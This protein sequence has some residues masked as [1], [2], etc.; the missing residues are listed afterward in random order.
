M[1]LKRLEENTLIPLFYAGP[2]LKEGPLPTV[3]Y[4]AL[5]AE[6]SLM[7]D[8]FNQ[9]VSILVNR[10]IR[11][12]SCDLPFHGKDFDSREALAGWAHAF[13]QGKDIVSEFLVNLK[14]SL[15]RLISLGVV[16]NN[17]IGCMGVSRGGFLISHLAAR[18]E[19]IT[20]L[21]HFAPLTQI[22]EGKDFS[23]LELSPLLQ[24]LNL[25]NF[26][27]LLHAKTQRIYIGNRDTRVGTSSCFNWIS[28]LV[29]TA[30]ENG[31]RSPHIEL[32]IKPS[33]GHMGHGTSKESFEQGALWLAEQMTK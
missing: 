25:T 32:F 16:A 24:N 6:E 5:S 8:P 22:T 13:A 17:T 27:Y 20:T 2:Y 29:E 31:I 15:S 7:T 33:I 3:L 21:L 28:S 4:L 26:S 11:V 12:F 14:A 1:N 30:H 23:F 9:P 10:G 19:E 18:M